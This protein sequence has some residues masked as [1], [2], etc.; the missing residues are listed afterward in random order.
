MTQDCMTKKVGTSCEIADPL[1]ILAAPRSFSSVVCAMLG[2]HPQMHG[3]PETHLF[4]DEVLTQWLQRSSAETYPMAH[5]LL[6]AV[7]QLCFGEQTDSS[8][9]LAFGW[10]KRRS[11]STS[12]MIFEELAV[13]AAPS[14][15]VDKSPSMVYSFESMLRV[16]RFFPQARFIHLT[17]HPRGHAYSVLKYL[18]VLAQPEYRPR[19]RTSEGDAVPEWVRNLASFP[20]S[21]AG[22]EDRSETHEDPQSGWYVLNRNIMTFLKS[23]PGHQCMVVRGEDL[24]TEPDRGLRNITEWLGL[25]TDDAAIEEMKHPERSPYARFGPSAARCGNDLF[26]F[27]I[28]SCVRYECAQRLSKG[29]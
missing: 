18:H 22:S 12:G 10:L 5:G 21:P 4:G 13:R 27:R 28:P 9:Q 26:F 1:F 14:M 15:L 16:Y 24:L 20:Y 25:R 8:I 2:V 7:A 23:V 19:Q 11:S 17:R 3:L 29:H 6:R